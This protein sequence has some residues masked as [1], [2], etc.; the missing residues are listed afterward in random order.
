MND[1]PRNGQVTLPD[2]SDERVDR[3]ERALFAA[4]DEERE[5]AAR[6]SS[7]PASDWARARRRRDGVG[8][9]A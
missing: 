4:I 3:I 2:L 1:E 5:A 7:Q 6:R 9:D 8:C